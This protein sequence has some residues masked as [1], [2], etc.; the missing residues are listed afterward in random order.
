VV[1]VVDVVSCVAQPDNIIAPVAPAVTNIK[2]FMNHFTPMCCR[3]RTEPTQPKNSGWIP[4][5]F[6][7]YGSVPSAYLFHTQGHLLRPLPVIGVR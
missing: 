3:R 2:V 7:V 5:A 6:A 4:L 1:V